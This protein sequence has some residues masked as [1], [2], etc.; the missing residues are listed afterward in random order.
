[1]SRPSS[2]PLTARLIALTCALIGFG[3]GAD[4]EFDLD[5]LAQR[6][7]IAGEQ[8]RA[9]FLRT[10]PAERVTWGGLAAS[11]ALGLG[12]LVERTL[13][14]RQRK[15]LP[16][17]F[18]ERFLDRLR[19]GKL[20]R[21]KA[22]DFCELNPSPAARVAHVAVRRWGRPP[23]EL[24]R[25][26]A[27]ARQVEVDRLRRHV[28]TLQRISAL[29]PLLGLLGTLFGAERALQGLPASAAWGRSCAALGA[30]DRRRGPGYPRPGRLRRPH[31]TG[32]EADQ[33]AGPPRGRDDRRHRR[34]RHRIE[35]GRGQTSRRR[36]RPRPA[37]RRA[38]A[39]PN[40]LARADLSP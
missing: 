7:S 23:A 10:P 26:V 37:P 8:A 20:D 4:G 30:V 39:N 29:A 11:A 24:E 22:A 15:I 2:T 32:R 21:G 19:D 14:L 33:R 40:R 18:S 31:G 9:W 38:R 16:R 12:V 1:M 27:M 34:R 13:R 25:A 17:A 35:A 3:L 36:G 5:S 28:G 6:A